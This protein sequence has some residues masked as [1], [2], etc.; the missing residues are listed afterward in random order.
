[1]QSSP[2]DTP[3]PLEALTALLA[4]A[5]DLVTGLASDPFFRRVVQAF[6]TLPEADREPI[7]GILERDATWTRIAEKTA[8]A[9]GISV[10]PNPH[11]S[12]YLHVVDTQTATAGDPDPSARDAS[13]MRLGIERF[14]SVLPLLFQEGVYAQW[15]PA[16]REV[17]RSATPELRAAASRLAREVLALIAEADAGGEAPA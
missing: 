17:A 7:L 12:L 3:T 14:V 10:R 15:S 2:Q 13:V 5:R 1:M 4:A 8:G 9:T 11:A 16:A 6:E